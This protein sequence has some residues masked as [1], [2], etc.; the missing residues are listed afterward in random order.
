MRAPLVILVLAAPAHGED[1]ELHDTTPLLDRGPQLELDPMFRPSL[2]GLGATSETERT[3]VPLGD[4]AR[5]VF[6]GTWWANVDSDEPGRFSRVVDLENRG[7]RTGV[8][9]ERDLGFATLAIHGSYNHV[10]SRYGSG[11]YRDIGVSLFRKWRL[12][13]WMTAWISLGVSR[14]TWLG[15]AA[16][17][18]EAKEETQATLGIGTTFR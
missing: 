14:R 8:R 12:T 9:F 2:E 1:L 10:D 3:V 18:G 17:A 6:E 13:R 16:P 5:A 7:W 4:K 15:D 11:T